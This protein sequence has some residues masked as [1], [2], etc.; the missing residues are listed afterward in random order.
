M[1]KPKKTNLN[2][3]LLQNWKSHHNMTKL[4][5]HWI[6]I[7]GQ[8]YKK[9]LVYQINRLLILIFSFPLCSLCGKTWRLIDARFARAIPFFPPLSKQNHYFCTVHNLFT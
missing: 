8:K 9:L 7:T 4:C 1:E 6:K 5:V 2:P 3:I